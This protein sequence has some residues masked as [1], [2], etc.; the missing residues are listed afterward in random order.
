[1]SSFSPLNTIAMKSQCRANFRPERFDTIAVTGA[2]YNSMVC[3]YVYMALILGRFLSET[4][5][6]S[7]ADE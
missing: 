1:M 4:A 5:S 6:Y 2:G 7:S 3:V